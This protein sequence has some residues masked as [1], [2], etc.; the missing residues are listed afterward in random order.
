M[1]KTKCLSVFA[2]SVL[3]FMQG[4]GYGQ[5]LVIQLESVSL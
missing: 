3:L 5:G 1:F 4:L 2:V